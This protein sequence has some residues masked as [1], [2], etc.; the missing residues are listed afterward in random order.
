M[1]RILCLSI[2]AV[3]IVFSVAA[4]N[5]NQGATVDLTGAAFNDLVKTIE[6]QTS[7]HFYYSPAETDSLIINIKLRNATLS[8]I[9][10]Q[11]LS[12]TDLHYS[13]F[14]NNVY[15]TKGRMILTQLPANFFSDGNK[16]G[17]DSIA[18][19]LTAFER[20]EKKGKTAEEKL[21][22][23]GPKTTNLQ[24]EAILSGTIKDIRTGEALVGASVFIE[25]TSLGVATDPFGHYSLKLPRGRLVIK[26]Q[27][28][29]MKSTRRHVMLYGTGN[30]NVEMEE[31]IMPLKEV[32]V[33]A[34]ADVRVTGMQMGL[35]KIDI[36]TAK[37][38]PLALGEPDILKVLMTL[39]GV[40]TVGEGTVGLNVRGGATSQNLILFN[41]AVVYNPSHLFGF[42]STF[43][44]DIVK[45]AEILKSGIGAEFGG[46]LSSVLEVHGREGNLKKISGSGGISPIAGRLTLEGPILKE[47]TSFL[48]GVRST[49]SDWLLHQLNSKTLKNSDASFYDIT[50]NISHKINDNNSVSING[51]ISKDAFK[52]GN[53]TTYH[54]S[55]RNASLKWKHIF[56]KKIYSTVMGGL[57]QYNYSVS[58]S[59]NP[60]N[61]FTMDFKI[62]QWNAK[63]DFIFFPAPRHTV[64][65]GAS[66]IKY[67][68]TPG[69]FQPYGQQSLAIPDVLQSEQGTESALYAGENFDINTRLSVYVGMRYSF[70]AYRGP[71]DVYE[72]ANGQPRQEI[73][74]TDTTHYGSGQR[75][76]NY[77]GIEPRASMRLVLSKNSSLK[78]SYNRMRQYLQM[79]SNTTAMTPTDIWKLSDPY[80]KPQVGD[81]VSLG[82]YKN[83][84]GNMFEFSAE[85]YYKIIQ[86]TVDYKNGAVLLLNHH[87]ETD[88]LNAN[89]KAYGL[90]IMLRKA[91]GRLN[92]WLSY[93]YS[94]TFLQ[95]Q[96]AYSSETINQG[97]YYPASY[98]KPHAV[99]FIGNYK[100]NRRL[101]FSLTT[102]YSTGRPITLPLVKYDIEGSGR[103]YYSD[104][105]QYRIPDYFRTD[106]SFNIEGNHKIKKFTH[107]SW[108]IAVYN[109]FGRHNPYS[110]YFV[111]KN[112]VINGYQL[113]IFGQ[114]IPTVTYNFRF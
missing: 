62:K 104:R 114:A 20:T 16:S 76:V 61:A 10:D 64:T 68:L 56:S 109:L 58:A 52:L 87:L 33:Q 95:T 35:E 93:T 34:E 12:G 49:Y 30:L 24:G 43:N 17:A 74:I 83:M 69:N 1:T 8:R 107:S 36:K 84:R 18:F 94:R 89:G 37:Q 88:V 105:N 113:S 13:L 45:S 97:Q 81:Q 19:D 111:S 53:D 23:V 9:L 25:N 2:L 39:P 5:E 59:N 98:D 11:A 71:K 102:V 99:N 57:S 7:F 60:V 38:I 72:Y 21:Y 78:M 100:F 63:A 103:V 29:G 4:Q 112:G 91:A 54:Y 6:D 108:T 3:S 90:E 27:S 110:V 40:Q 92:G 96:G 85:A 79:L 32:V 50:A 22:F 66:V 86:N 15:I 28:V 26:I 51:Y 82:F 14:E 55:D 41:D 65:A 47:K 80:I 75:I 46:R 77:N 67:Q 44:S 106:I 31:D 70:Y 101:N 42:F 73:S 48:I